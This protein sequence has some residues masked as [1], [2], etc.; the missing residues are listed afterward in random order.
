MTVPSAL[1]ISGPSGC[2]KSSMLSVVCKQI[3]NYY[4][5]ISTT[6]RPKRDGEVDGVDY[7][8]VSTEQFIQDIADD[9]FLEW[10]K[11]HNNYYGTAKRPILDAISKDQ[12][13]IFDIDVQGFHILRDKISNHIPSVFITTPSKQELKHR[14]Q[15]R[16][17]DSAKDI[18]TRL[19]NAT[20]EM[21]EAMLY[22]HIIINKQLDISSKILLDIINQTHD[23]TTTKPCKDILSSW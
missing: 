8:F 7:F 1:L 18:R 12:L 9:Q 19:A 11:V 5:S 21:S 23:S 20:T 13:I 3:E 4:F 22:D 16:A 15:S 17:K 14:L 6:T 2:G 10:A